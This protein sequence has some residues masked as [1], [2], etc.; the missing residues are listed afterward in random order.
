MR[1]T[2]MHP[3]FKNKLRK[4]TMQSHEPSASRDM[5]RRPHATLD[6]ASRHVKALKIERLLGL[7]SLPQP[8]RLLE[9]GT[10]AGGIA[11]YFATHSQLRCEVHAVDVV[12]S[13]QVTEGYAFR[14][15]PGVELPHADASF[16]VVISNHVIEHVGDAEAQARHLAEI[17]RVLKPG[18]VGYLAVPNRWMLTEPHYGL[19]FLS[20][21]PRTWR[22]PYLRLMGK[23]E[24]YDCEPL[25]MEQLERMLVKAG[26]RCRNLCVDAIREMLAIE[27]PS[28]LGIC[29][30]SR[31]PNRLW[32]LLLK[33][34]PTLIYR[35]ERE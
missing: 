8:M 18:G 9:I 6:L 10:G 1:A 28:S 31:V 27:H 3:F 4:L 22:T 7:S 26:L 21:W 23:G 30:L 24:F 12:D 5:R 25:E 34:M 20:W 16:D 33:L 11:H 32:V 29:L 14:Q 15:V 35:L 13:R 17:R 19:K 2:R